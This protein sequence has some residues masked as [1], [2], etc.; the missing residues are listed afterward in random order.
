MGMNATSVIGYGFPVAA[1]EA[2]D[3][4][5]MFR[6]GLLTARHGGFDEASYFFLDEACAMQLDWDTPGEFQYPVVT[7]GARQRMAELAAELNIDPAQIKTY[8]LVYYG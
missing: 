1:E 6:D 7:D 4:R 3:Y 5:Y 8:W 2:L